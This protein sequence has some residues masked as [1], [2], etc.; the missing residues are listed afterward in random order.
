MLKAMGRIRR[1]LLEAIP[2]RSHREI[3]PA[4]AAVRKVHRAMEHRCKHDLVVWSCGICCP[5][6][7]E[8]QGPRPDQARAQS[9]LAGSQANP[10]R[11][12]PSYSGK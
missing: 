3:L 1:N 12:M 9:A 7:R 5:P 2:P 8:E 6:V 10:P 11:A 4:T